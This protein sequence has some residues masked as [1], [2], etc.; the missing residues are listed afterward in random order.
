LVLTILIMVDCRWDRVHTCYSGSRLWTTGIAKESVRTYGL[1]QSTI[2]FFLLQ[3]YLR[4]SLSLSQTCHEHAATDEMGVWMGRPP[5]LRY[6]SS[7]MG[8]NIGVH[9]SELATIQG[10]TTSSARFKCDVHRRVRGDV[11]NGGLPI[12]PMQLSMIMYY[13]IFMCMR[14]WW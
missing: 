1:R 6:V 11:P 5:S 8:D 10:W 14:L 12:H 3:R 7:T 2:L 13:G 9:R 4:S